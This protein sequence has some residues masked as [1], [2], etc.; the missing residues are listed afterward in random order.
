MGCGCGKSTPSRPVYSAKPS[1]SSA[2]I[3]PPSLHRVAQ[4]PPVHKPV[5]VH[6]PPAYVPI[7]T[8]LQ[9]VRRL[10]VQLPSAYRPAN[11]ADY[12]RK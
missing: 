6:L 2:A 12:R 8:Q 5:S 7:N 9:P 4:T 10:N 3:A 1:R 11:A